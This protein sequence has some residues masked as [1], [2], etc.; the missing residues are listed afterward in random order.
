MSELLS[1]RLFSHTLS[2][3]L[4]HYHLSD[5]VKA[6]HSDWRFSTRPMQPV[7]VRNRAREQ[8]DQEEKRKEV[9]VLLLLLLLH[10]HTTGLDWT[11]VG[12]LI[13][14]LGPKQKAWE[15]VMGL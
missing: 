11:R 12:G 2:V 15:G 4:F 7:A 1:D 5:G 13:D 8:E 14:G 10:P 3:F 6:R 9:G